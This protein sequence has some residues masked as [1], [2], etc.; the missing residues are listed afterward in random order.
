MSEEAF[1]DLKEAMEGALAFERGE[2]R[3]EGNSN[4]GS[5]TARRNVAQRHRSDT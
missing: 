5:A 1:A 2:Q 3:F 4:P